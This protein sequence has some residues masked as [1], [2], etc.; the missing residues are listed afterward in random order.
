MRLHIALFG[1]ARVVVGKSDVDLSFDSPSVTLGQL[2]EELIARYPRVRPYLLDASG[3]LHASLRVLLNNEWPI[4]E[5]TMA[6][7]LHDED[8]VSFLVAVAGGGEMVG[9]LARRCGSCP[10]HER[11]NV[12]SAFT[13]VI[14]QYTASHHG[15]FSFPSFS[16]ILCN[17][18]QYLSTL[19]NTFA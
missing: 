2:I 4:P 9:G 11:S 15:L 6:T 12:E 13:N 1:G 14:V 3:M 7:L 5:V 10:G 8:R 19:C 16:A 17:S 18:Y